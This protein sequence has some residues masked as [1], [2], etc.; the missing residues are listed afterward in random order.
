LI[1]IA[2]IIGL[3]LMSILVIEMKEDTIHRI[4]NFY[5]SIIAESASRELG[6][7][8]FDLNNLD[9]KQKTFD[10]F[11]RQIKTDE[12]LRIKVWSSDGTIISSDDRSI[13]GNNYKDNLRFQNSI[14]GD[15][16]SEIKNPIDPENISEIGYGQ[17]MEI[18]IPITLD[19][20]S[21][22][23]VI[24][25]YY[26]MDSINDSITETQLMIMM[27]MVIFISII[28]FGIVFFS[29][30]TI[31]SYNK[32]I[33]QEKFASIGNLSSRMAHDIRNPLTIIKTT[34]DILKTKNKN[35]SSDE[36]EKLKKL[37]DQIYRISHQVNNVLDYIKGQPLTLKI[38]SLKE[39]I[40]S[41]INDLPEHKGIEIE[42]TIAKTK[43]HCDYEAIK[44]V[45]INLFYN[46][47]QSLGTEGKIKISS[48]ITGDDIIIKIE[49]SGSGIPKGKLDKIFEPLYTTKQEGTGLG[50]AS[51]KSIIEQHRGT[52]S[53]KN[54]PTTFIITLPTD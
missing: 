13:I 17:M 53:V 5:P 50:L 37:D 22:I 2:L 26:N 41:S 54:N 28:I 43:I 15:T 30:F 47:I 14:A 3:S 40:D 24:E 48:E 31:R 6:Q 46:A 21:P 1:A 32:T 29:I 11:F 45:F 4:E 16:T 25:L 52:I 27:N 20:V 49:D 9:E 33:E 34:L 36:L 39:I 10:D 8:D 19:S 18:Y 44:V 35:L 38:N 23:G 12:M 42:S 51:C 7:T